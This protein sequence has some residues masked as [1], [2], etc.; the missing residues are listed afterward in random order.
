MMSTIVDKVNKDLQKVD[1]RLRISY[2]NEDI[3]GQD[4]EEYGIEDINDTKHYALLLDDENKLGATVIK[5]YFDFDVRWS[6][7][8]GRN[9]KDSLEWAGFSKEKILQVENVLLSHARS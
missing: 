6:L 2:D 3:Y 8:L 5:E 9:S 1:K 4:F 7:L